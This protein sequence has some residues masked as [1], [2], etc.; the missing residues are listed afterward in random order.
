M[1]RKLILLGLISLGVVLLDQ[2]TKQWIVSNF[3]HG[4][5]LEVMEHFFHITYVRNYAAAFGMLSQINPTVRSAFFLLIPPTA[6]IIIVMMLRGTTAQE[7]IRNMALCGVFAGA[8]GNYIDRLSF[9]YVV[10]FLDF[11][12]YQKYAWP[13]FNV[14]DMS[15]VCGVSVLILLEFWENSAKKQKNK[16]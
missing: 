7:K 12:Y 5:S 1:K 13:A 9:G 14:A 4:E 11:H 15:I 10:D 3:K 6:M 2:L 16:K 8:L